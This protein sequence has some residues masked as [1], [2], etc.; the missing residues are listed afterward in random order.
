MKYLK[1]II[2]IWLLFTLFICVGGIIKY[3]IDVNTYIDQKEPKASMHHMDA[4][5]HG[6]E[7]YVLGSVHIETDKIK[8][9]D[10][11]HYLDSISPTVILYESDTKSVQRM[12]NRTDFF[13]Q[14]M[15]TFKKGNKVESFVSLKYIEYHPECEIF[16]YEWEERDSYHRKHDILSKSSEMLNAVIRLHREHVLTSDQSATVEEF[17]A[18]NTEISNIGRNA[19]IHDINNATT[20]SILRNRQLYVYD[21]IPKIVKERK[22]LKA[23]QD[24]VPRHMEYWD[25]RNRAMA[26]NII[27]QIKRNPNK[28]IVV[29]NGYYHR[30]YLIDELK[31]HEEDL[32]FSVK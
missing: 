17:L 27:N 2:V 30:Y 19:N 3:N 20:D 11:Y 22:E 13:R 24:F 18:L 28:K 16:S 6:T 8:R 31:K 25:I 7:V 1:Y 32:N 12:L 4:L 14:L 21:H 29:L 9:D 10:L 15:S 5:P 23:Y 26:Q